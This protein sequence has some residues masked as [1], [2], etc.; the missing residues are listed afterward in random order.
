MQQTDLVFGDTPINRVCIAD[1]DDAQLEVL[2]ERFQTKRMEYHTIYQEAQ[3]LKKRAKYE[4]DA[5]QLE[6]RLTQ[7][8]KLLV[9]MDN[10]LEKLRKYS[11][12]IRVLR[13]ITEVE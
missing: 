8:Q 2:I 11:V 13:E 5:A 7:M 12:E 10:A 4:K 1:L 3:E 9:T 6:K